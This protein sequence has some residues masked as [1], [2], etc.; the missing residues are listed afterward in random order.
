LLLLLL[1]DLR[2]SAAHSFVFIA[3]SHLGN[4]NFENDHLLP[5]Q[6]C[7]NSSLTYIF[8]KK[9]LSFFL[10]VNFPQ[11]AYF[12]FC[13][14]LKILCKKVNKIN[15]RILSAQ[16]ILKRGKNESALK[17]LTSLSISWHQEIYYICLFEIL[18]LIMQIHICLSFAFPRLFYCIYFTNFYQKGVR[19][20]FG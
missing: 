19:N 16:K 12:I 4:C 18:N 7:H 13:Y 15:D 2:L 8:F 3:L 10:N 17:R 9:N 14:L 6:K 5:T 11:K 1:C 20:I